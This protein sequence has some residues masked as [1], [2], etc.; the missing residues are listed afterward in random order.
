MAKRKRYIHKYKDER[1]TLNYYVD[2]DDLLILDFRDK[3]IPSNG[4]S[5]ILHSKVT[6]DWIFCTKWY[7]EILLFIHNP[8]DHNY[9]NKKDIDNG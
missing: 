8:Q 6:K 5:A 1:F 4:L 9:D 3:E 7:T 2:K